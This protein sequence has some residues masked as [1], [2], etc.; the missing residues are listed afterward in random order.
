[1]FNSFA[2]PVCKVVKK[3]DRVGDVFKA[4]QMLQQQDVLVG[5][6]AEKASRRG[7]GINNAELGF[8]L[9]EGVRA[10]SMR[11]EMENM[12]A[13]GASYSAAYQAYLLHHGNPL[14]HS[15][16]RPFLEPA[17]KANIEK[18][19]KYQALV[20]RAALAGDK[21]EMGAASQRLGM[22]GQNFVKGWFTDPRNE[23]PENA[24]ATIQAKGSD[25]PNIDTSQVRNAITYVIRGKS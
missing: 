19:A 18:I 16:P 13:S 3:L 2:K 20:I 22:L 6:P 1:M 24:P 23:W 12:Q 4:L 8:L 10:E 21:T 25:R 7:Q 14:W 5:I 17:I 9:S 15:P 11:V